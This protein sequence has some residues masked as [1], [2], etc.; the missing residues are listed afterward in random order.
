MAIQC[1]KV[2]QRGI[3]HEQNRKPL[4]NNEFSLLRNL[5]DVEIQMAMTTL[6]PPSGLPAQEAG[7]RKGLTLCADI[8]SSGD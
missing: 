3:N 7:L 5:I 4:R 8:Q 1:K 2:I 6:I